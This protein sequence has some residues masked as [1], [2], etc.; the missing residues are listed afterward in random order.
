MSRTRPMVSRAGPAWTGP[1]GQGEIR[2]SDSYR[3]G[4]SGHTSRPVGNTGI[5]R[6]GRYAEIRLHSEQRRNAA[7]EA[8]A[9]AILAW[10]QRNASEMRILIIEGEARARGLIRD[11]LQGVGSLEVVAEIGDCGG[12]PAAFHRYRPDMVVVDRCHAETV[13]D[14]APDAACLLVL[15]PGQED[16]L[17]ALRGLVG[18]C[19]AD[20]GPVQPVS[21]DAGAGEE[22]SS[23][24][25]AP[26][27]AGPAPYLRRAMS[28]VGDH[29][30]VFDVDDAYYVEAADNY[31]RFVLPDREYL[32][33]GS[34]AAFESRL[35][36]RHFVRVHRSAI[37]NVRHLVKLER[38]FSRDLLAILPEGKK[39]RVSRTYR[40]RLDPLLGWGTA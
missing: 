10:R 33:P 28:R 7:T 8:V 22:T 15:P 16:L 5:P 20:G 21:G 34:L 36:P 37:L 4:P 23:P 39:L 3:A 17:A 29:Y 24:A 19:D 6:P 25:A 1:A 32:V 40:D 9:R 2:R 13:I 12:A 26:D 18:G 31:A 27:A 38:W 35:D 30:E 14:S 11:A